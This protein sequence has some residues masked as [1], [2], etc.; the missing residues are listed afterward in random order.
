MEVRFPPDFEGWRQAARPLLV[1]RVPPSGLI[2]T[3]VEGAA[4][5]PPPG[6]GAGPRI[7]AA[8]V[9]LARRAAGGDDRER[10]ALLYRLAFRITGGERGLLDQEGDPDV[11]ALLALAG[12]DDGGLGALANAARVCRQCPLH[13]AATQTVFGE[14]PPDARMM[15]VGEQPGDQEDRAGHP[16]VGPAGEVLDRAL[17]VVGLERRSLYVTNAVKHFKFEARGKRRIHQ[18]PEAREI[19]ACKPWLLAEIER[20]RPAVLVAL[21]STAAQSL[22]GPSV[23]TMRDRGRPVAS[24]LAPFCLITYHPSAALRATDMTSANQIENDLRDDLAL[25]ASYLATAT[26]SSPLPSSPRP[27]SRLPSSPRRRAART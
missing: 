5:A 16:F 13:A 7:P 20:V 15:L 26:A 21:G 9:P 11:A 25:A 14:G 17:A 3:P 12:P 1:A 23:R 19:Q 6:D 24:P 10:W 8:F 4:A 18:R 27:S 2:W 22:F